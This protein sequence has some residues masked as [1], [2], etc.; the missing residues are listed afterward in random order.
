MSNG[1]TGVILRVDATTGKIEKQQMDE[2]FYRM[3][4]GGGSFG[5]YF[6]LKETSADTDPLAEENVLTIAPGITTG[7]AISGVSRCC[8]T[9]LSPETGA[10]GDSQA[11][12]SIGPMIKRAGYDAIV[13]T[14]KAKKLSY[15][16]V[17]GDNVQI[18]DATSLKGK[19]VLEVHDSFTAEFDNK[20][21]SVLQHTHSKILK[22][23]TG[24]VLTME[25]EPILR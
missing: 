11:G 17:D 7:A 3:Y 21:I 23:K 13:I 4:M 12:G 25:S 8:I 2:D 18:K 14:G 22:I 16:L 1:F 5:A 19:T 10:V 24:P 9:A 20:K 15:L 6:L